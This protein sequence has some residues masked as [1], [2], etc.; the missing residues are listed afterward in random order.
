MQVYAGTHVKLHDEIVMPP[1]STTWRANTEDVSVT[2]RDVLKR[3]VVESSGQA[4][5]PHNRNVQRN[6]DV[7]VWELVLDLHRG[8]SQRRLFLAMC[9]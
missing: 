1:E 3:S 9:S 2:L 6:D 4:K 7:T 5:T 8:W